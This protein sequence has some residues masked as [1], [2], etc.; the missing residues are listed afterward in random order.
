MGRMV[1]IFCVWLFG[2][3]GIQQQG[4][5][6]KN[7]VASLK[8]GKTVHRPSFALPDYPA[9]RSRTEPN[10]GKGNDFLIDALFVFLLFWFLF[11]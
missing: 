9:N 10:D 2:S 7:Q 5:C 6:A 4:L 8:M 1:L 11:Y 3:V